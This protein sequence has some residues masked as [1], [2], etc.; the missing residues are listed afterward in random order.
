[1]ILLNY[2][3][4]Y[5]L[6]W[7][8]L[9][10]HPRHAFIIL[11]CVHAELMKPDSDDASG[12]ERKKNRTSVTKEGKQPDVC[13][14]IQNVPAPMRERDSFFYFRFSLNFVDSFFCTDIQKVP[15]PRRE[16]ERERERER[17]RKRE[18]ERER[19]RESRVFEGG[20]ER[21]GFVCVRARRLCVLCMFVC[22]C[23]CVFVR[24]C[25]SMHMY[26]IQHM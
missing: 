18:R 21:G 19:E 2:Y 7:L 4:S 1:M 26:Y 11:G 15:A 22:V 8:L 20:R 17:A 10:T 12:Q 6:F 16:R 13:A 3:C 14:D 25:V 9:C 24:V 23:V 5:V